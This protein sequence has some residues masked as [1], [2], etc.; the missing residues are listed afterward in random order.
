[1]L[2]KI[3]CNSMNSGAIDEKGNVFVWGAGKHGLLGNP[4]QKNPIAK[5]IILTL[6]SQNLVLE[7]ENE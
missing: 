2:R 5:P 7:N 3:A 6:K 1:M 4:K